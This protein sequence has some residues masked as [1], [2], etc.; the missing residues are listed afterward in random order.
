MLRRLD[1]PL[2]QRSGWLQ[3]QIPGGPSRFGVAI[4]FGLGGPKKL[5][6]STA[7]QSIKIGADAEFGVAAG[8]LGARKL[9]TTSFTIDNS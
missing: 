1:S 8:Q 4:S 6:P 9:N 2:L 5:G 3:V 7:C